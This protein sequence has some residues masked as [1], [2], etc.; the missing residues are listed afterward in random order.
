MFLGC[1]KTLLF[2]SVVKLTLKTNIIFSD[3][4]NP[5]I[6]INPKQVYK[7]NIYCYHSAKQNIQMTSIA[8]VELVKVDV[9]H[10]Q[11]FF[12]LEYNCT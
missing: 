12:Y 7:E 6:P 3:V 5:I 2:Y 1:C 4:F 9:L 11:P 8:E 10:M